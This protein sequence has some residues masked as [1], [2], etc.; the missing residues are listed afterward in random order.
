MNIYQIQEAINEMPLAIQ[1][2][3]LKSALA[4]I[5]QKAD[6]EGAIVPAE[7]E[8]IMQCTCQISLNAVKQSLPANKRK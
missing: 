1:L 5:I 6:D 7:I 4:N 2:K 3:L 8:A